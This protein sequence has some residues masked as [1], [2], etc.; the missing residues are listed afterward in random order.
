MILTGA[1]DRFC[2]ETLHSGWGDMRSA[3]GR[4]KIYRKGRRL[5]TRLLD[6][7]VP[8]IGVVD[9]PAHQHAE[10]LVMC[11]LVLAGLDRTVST[12]AGA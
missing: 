3:L 12:G 4:D 9:G 5:L 10:L 8:M 11:D 6:I 1:G 2:T 7:E